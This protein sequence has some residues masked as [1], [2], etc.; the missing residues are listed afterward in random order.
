MHPEI[1]K[2]HIYR[3]KLNEYILC[4]MEKNKTETKKIN[5]YKKR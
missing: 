5:D 1:K 3:S 4:S 2:I